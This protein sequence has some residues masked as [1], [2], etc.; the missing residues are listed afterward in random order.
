MSVT[1]PHI[2]SP[3]AQLLVTS[4]LGVSCTLSPPSG[5]DERLGQELRPWR[6]MEAA[7][8]SGPGRPHD[9]AVPEPSVTR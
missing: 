5:S 8:R 9:P 7:S 3:H 6:S 4:D 1:A 2:V